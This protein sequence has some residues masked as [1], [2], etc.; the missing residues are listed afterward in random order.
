MSQTLHENPD[1]YNLQRFVEAQQPV[2]ERVRA[3]L[4]AG[5]K[6]SHWMWFIFPQLKGLGR[7]PTAEYFGIASLPEA[8]AYWRHPVLGRRLKE[9]TELVVAILG[10]TAHQIF[11]SPDDVKFRS[12]MTLFERAAPEEPIFGQALDK[13]F[14]GKRDSSTLALLP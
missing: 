3:E 12:C 1:A 2:Y 7:S 10:K 11:G 5:A 4:R 9:C 14:D 13:Y 6:A 8:E